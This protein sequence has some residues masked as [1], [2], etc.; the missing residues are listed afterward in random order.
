M[1]VL[2]VDDD[3]VTQ[4]M[5]ATEL[6]DIELIKAGRADDGFRLATHADQPDAVVIDIVLPDGDGLDLVR[7]LRHHLG[8]NQMPIVV[9]TAGHDPAREA[10][11]LAAGADA[12]LAKPFDPRLV[13]DH[14]LAIL[15]VPA[16]ER[17]GRRRASVD[18]LRQGRPAVPL[19]PG[20]LAQPVPDARHDWWKRAALSES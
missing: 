13:A 18:N 17:R 16:A 19:V 15:E 1:R 10:D 7:R 4:V 20:E 12:Y 14:L 2:A 8:L 11:V 5:L 6:D 3:A 9:L